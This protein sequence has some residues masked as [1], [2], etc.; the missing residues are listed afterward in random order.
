MD[1]D[2]TRRKGSHDRIVTSFE[3]REGDI[4]LG[5][6]MVAKGHDF[7]GVTLVGIISADTGLH[8]PDFRSGERTYQLLTQTAGRAGRRNQ[9]G[10]V[11]IQTHSA[12]HPVLGFA[13]HQ[14]YV[15]FYDWEVAQ[16]KELGYPPWGRLVAIRFKGSEESRVHQAAQAFCGLVPANATYIRLGPVP[17]PIARAKGLYRYQVI[18]KASKESDPSGSTIRKAIREAA[19]RYI[20]SPRDGDVRMAID[21]DPVE[22][23]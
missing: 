20:S 13:I 5:T 2:T 6:Q 7:P 1:Q 9:Q 16:R 12:D 15:R 22:M 10:E 4:L 18:F 17:S 14:D 11:I 23:L 8:F 3:R 21:V 19:V